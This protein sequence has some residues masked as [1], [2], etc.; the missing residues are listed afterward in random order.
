MKQNVVITLVGKQS[1][2]EEPVELM[3]TG[4]LYEK[5]N[6][7]YL[8]YEEGP[9]AHMEAGSVTLKIEREQR[10]TVTRTRKSG[11]SQLIIEQ[12]R[13]HQCCYST[14]FGQLIIGVSGKEIVNHLSVNGGHLAFCYGLDFN[15]NFACDCEMTF[16][17]SPT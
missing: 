4:V 16:D 11:R 12:G 14:E 5:P 3:T 1:G 10:I 9:S 15:A 13:R 8:C 7:F 2:Q 17:I 6:A